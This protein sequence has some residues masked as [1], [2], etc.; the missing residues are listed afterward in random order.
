MKRTTLLMMI[1]LLTITLVLLLLPSHKLCSIGDS[2]QVEVGEGDERRELSEETCRVIL[3]LREGCIINV[4]DVNYTGIVILN[5]TKGSY[6]KVLAYDFENSSHKF[7]F[8]YWKIDEKVYGENPLNLRCEHDL[9]IEPVFLVKARSCSKLPLAKLLDFENAVPLTE[10]EGD[11]VHIKEGYI[12]FKRGYVFVP[13]R[14]PLPLYNKSCGGWL[15]ISRVKARVSSKVR[16]D[17]GVMEDLMLFLVLDEG[18]D[19]GRVLETPVVAIGYWYSGI[20]GSGY[21][22][23]KWFFFNGRGA[24]RLEYLA[25]IRERKA[26]EEIDICVLEIISR[27]FLPLEKFQDRYVMGIY[28]FGYDRGFVDFR[29][30]LFEYGGG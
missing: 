26:R 27:N 21:A 18:V 12:E 17:E 13:L 1:T 10:F 11:Y 30:S 15:K 29:E 28:V 6:V 19:V 23:K 20:G 4:N 3:Q 9:R 2:Q 5:F 16:G 7:T 24:P 8:S 25:L 22:V 14:K